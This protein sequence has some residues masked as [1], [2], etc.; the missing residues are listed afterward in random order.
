MPSG[1]TGEALSV[2]IEDVRAAAIAGAIVATPLLHSR[3]LSGISGSE[4][5][6][7]LEN[8]QYTAS[9]KE[10][11][12]FN[13]LLGLSTSERAAGVVAMSA[14]NHAQAFAYHAKRLGIAATIVMPKPTPFVKVRNTER[15]EATVVLE[16]ED[17][18]AADAFAHRLARKDGHYFIHPYDDRAVISGQGTV[19]L[20]MLEASPDL[21]ILVVPVGGG[22]LIAGSNGGA[23]AISPDIEIIS[24]EAA[25]ST[26]R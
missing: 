21:E 6:L 23:K 8:M 5:Y 9:F 26:L 3:T 2:G 24:V 14:G 22:G 19:A 12:A 1:T 20:E 25:R 15:L 17:L 10:R 18:D 4:L 13:R 7:N 16:G 11:G